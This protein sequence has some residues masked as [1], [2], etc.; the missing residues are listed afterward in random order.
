MLKLCDLT[1]TYSHLHLVP[2]FGNGKLE[3]LGYHIQRYFRNPEFSR[4]ETI[5]ACDRH[6][7]R[8]KGKRHNSVAR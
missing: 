8:E 1:L 6:T 5:P 3:S 2:P 4:F 7:D